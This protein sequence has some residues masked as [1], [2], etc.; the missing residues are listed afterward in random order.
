[1]EGSKEKTV[2]VRNTTCTVQVCQKSKT[3]WEVSGVYMG[4]CIQEKGSSENSAVTAWRKRAEYQG[5]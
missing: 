2:R 5:V 4:K 3:V 1:M